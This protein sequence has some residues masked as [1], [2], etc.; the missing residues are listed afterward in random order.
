LF[1]GFTISYL[2]TATN[3]S[4]VL[5]MEPAYAELVDVIT[6]YDWP[7]RKVQEVN[8]FENFEG[9]LFIG[10]NQIARGAVLLLLM[11]VVAVA[12]E[13]DGDREWRN[14]N[15]FVDGAVVAKHYGS[16]IGISGPQEDGVVSFEKNNLAKFVDAAK[17]MTEAFFESVQ[18]KRN[19][20]FGDIVPPT[21]ARD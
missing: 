9:A 2:D 20:C 14:E 6:Q 11:E 1:E 8:F 19:E 15:A 3:V 16:S 10:E 7:D 18:L 21:S 5:K 17:R 4:L 13:T 12:F